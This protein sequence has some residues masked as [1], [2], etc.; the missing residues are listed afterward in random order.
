[1]TTNAIKGILGIAALALGLSAGAA[2]ADE[3]DTGMRGVGELDHGILHL[4]KE[5][6]A[7]VEDALEAR[8]YTIGAGMKSGRA[9]DTDVE[10]DGGIRD[11]AKEL[12]RDIER[13]AKDA[14][15]EGKQGLGRATQK[16]LS[17]ELSETLYKFQGDVGIE[18]TGVIDIP[19]LNALGFDAIVLIDPE[20]V[21][22]TELLP[23]MDIRYGGTPGATGLDARTGADREI[24]DTDQ[25]EDRPSEEGAVRIPDFLAK[26]P[27][28]ATGENPIGCLVLGEEQLEE[29]QDRLVGMD[30]LKDDPRG[31]IN[32]E[33]IDAMKQ[34]QSTHGV[35][36][37]EGLFG[38]STLAWFSFA[39]F[40]VELTNEPDKD[41]VPRVL[42]VEAGRTDVEK[43]P[44][45][46][47]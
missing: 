47:P 15:D 30:L 3:G 4:S 27:V 14:Y 45:P 11:D 38:L 17:G 22:G 44:S 40:D 34:F 12:G 37:K 13:G 2:W 32:Q 28:V 46:A 35:D 20:D 39:D 29:I 9:P 1:M 43:T 19:T 21:N 25:G 33:F 5:D 36:S 23:P 26:L 6:V 41:C 42:P 8:G 7:C 10:K 18:K 16:N 31:H 24:G